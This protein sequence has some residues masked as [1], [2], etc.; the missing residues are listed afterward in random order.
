MPAATQLKSLRRRA[1]L[2]VRGIAALLDIPAS[3]YQYYE[4]GYARAR[5]PLELSARLRPVLL[6]RGVAARD[7]DRLCASTERVAGLAPVSWARLVEWA[8]VMSRPDDEGGKMQ[9]AQLLPVPGSLREHLI[10]LRVKDA[11][12]T[13]VASFSSRLTPNLAAVDGCQ[14]G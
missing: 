4:R 9:D 8:D 2:S 11:D 5:L 1:G 13:S 10:A 6:D 14:V 7:V 12:L 3:S